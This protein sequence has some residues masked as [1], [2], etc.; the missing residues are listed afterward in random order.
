MLEGVDEVPWGRLAY[1]P[2]GSVEVPRLLREVTAAPSGSSKRSPVWRLW[3]GLFHTTRTYTTPGEVYDAAPYVV[4]YLM[5]V[6]RVARQPH[7]E[8]IVDLMTDI[9]SAQP[10]RDVSWDPAAGPEPDHAA[11][12]RAAMTARVG[13]ITRSLNDASPKV[14]VAVARLLALLPEAA[15]S[16]VP[17]LRARAEKGVRPA[18]DAGAVACVLAVAWLAAA[19]HVEWFAGLRD[20]GAAH[21]DLRAMAVVGLAL[22]SPDAEPDD[23]AAVALLADAQAD[24]ASA[25]QL[26]Q[27]HGDGLMPAD[28]ALLRAELWQQAV[29]RDLLARPGSRRIKQALYSAR[30]AIDHWRAAPADLLPAIA[31]RVRDLISAPSSVRRTRE[32]DEQDPLV[33]A[34]N[35]IARSGQAAAGHADLLAGLLTGDPAEPWPDVAAPAVDGLARLGDGRCV[36]WL[37]A[38][39]LHGYGHVKQFNVDDVLPP[40]VAHADALIP[41]LRTYLSSPQLNNHDCVNA[42][43]SWG[44]A[45]APLAPDLAVSQ[46]YLALPLFAA[47]GPAAI[48]VEAQVR[49]LLSIKVARPEAAWALWRITGEPGQAAALLTEDLVDG[50][51]DAVPMLEQL[52]PAAAAAVPMLRE[53]LHDSGRNRVAIARALW[54][55][56][57]DGE[58]LVAPLLDAI[59]RRPLPAWGWQWP[60]S[61]LRAVRALGTMGPVA[62]A[63][64]PAL[65]V[66]AHG[67]ARVT[68]RAVWADERYQRAAQDA[69]A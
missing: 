57:G 31:D 10:Y 2:G 54:A 28:S 18:R 33:D 66:I 56:T 52:G 16:S 32:H 60:P 46:A 64:A 50:G 44:P 63:A 51:H 40:M 20:A 39:F 65:E 37:A 5:E 61:G 55:I 38:A 4:P 11:L 14:V 35:V 58:G 7:R 8:L 23:D 68:D 13:A 29:T 15:P 47:I 62:A 45:A 30:E 19:D 21:G 36:P 12:A 42:L 27:W 6:M 53:H 24:P 3:S 59:T 69:L 41:A 49:A 67:R 22:S 1:W 17:A 25:F 9:A 43:I 34:V 26:V 48:E